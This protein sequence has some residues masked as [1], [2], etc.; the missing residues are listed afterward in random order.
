MNKEKLSNKSENK[1][2]YLE[3]DAFLRHAN[4][5]HNDVNLLYTNVI[6]NDVKLYGKSQLTVDR[7]YNLLLSSMEKL[8]ELTKEDNKV[9]NDTIHDTSVINTCEQEN[10]SDLSDIDLLECTNVNKYLYAKDS[11]LYL[12]S[13]KSERGKGY[14]KA[15]SVMNEDFKRTAS[16]FKNL[17]ESDSQ[18]YAIYLLTAIL[19]VWFER[20][21]DIT[22]YKNRL[23]LKDG[24]HK[25]VDVLIIHFA[26]L[27]INSAPS[28]RKEIILSFKDDLLNWISCNDNQ[29]TINGQNTNDMHSY[30][31][32]PPELRMYDMNTSSFT[33]YQL[34]KENN[35]IRS[36]L[37]IYL[38]DIIKPILYSNSIS[39][40]SNEMKEDDKYLHSIRFNFMNLCGHE[41][42]NENSVVEHCKSL[43]IL[44]D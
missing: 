36:E 29:H 23:S 10:D 26:T 7:I 28:Y 40:L 22:N 21:H 9:S 32:V 27:C 5:L 43:L 25:W 2:K 33:P 15:Y 20:R 37:A 39:V 14:H 17:A 1:I 4:A 13:N 18:Y 12:I 8:A 6:E 34:K 31:S 11:A 41:M 30:T 38:E 3:Y 42:V 16:Y 19:Q 24:Y 44:G 35:I